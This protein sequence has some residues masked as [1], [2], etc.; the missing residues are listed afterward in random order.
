MTL[1]DQNLRNNDLSKYKKEKKH[2]FGIITPR[3]ETFRGKNKTKQIKTKQKKTFGII[4]LRN[5]ELSVLLFVKSLTENDS[6]KCH[7][8]LLPKAYLRLFLLNY[9]LIKIDKLKY[10]KP[11]Y[12]Y[13]LNV[14]FIYFHA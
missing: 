2:T 11:F 4:T 13:I 1:R 9:S 8:K 3:N 6:S 10:L 5:I 12:S 7:S 14:L